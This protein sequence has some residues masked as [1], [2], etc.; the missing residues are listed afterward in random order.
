MLHHRVLEPVS[1]AE[2]YRYVAVMLFS[3][4]SGFSFDK[5]TDKMP[6]KCTKPLNLNR[7]WVISI[8]ILAFYVTGRGN[9]GGITERTVRCLCPYS[10]FDEI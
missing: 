10:Y 8:I 6:L 7:I 2:K 9:D 5:T 4:C 3:H 1:I